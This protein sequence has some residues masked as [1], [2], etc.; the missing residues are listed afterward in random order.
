M[1]LVEDDTLVADSLKKGLEG[2]GY[3]IA[4]ASRGDDGLQAAM[5]QAFDVVLSDLKMPGLSGLALLGQLHA[6]RPKLPVIL[7]TGFGTTETAI[8]ATRLVLLC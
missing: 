5:Q 2:A 6:A 8:E 4:L 1:L 3:D 7:M